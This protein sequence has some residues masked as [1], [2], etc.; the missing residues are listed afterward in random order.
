MSTDQR[1]SNAQTT[2]S[3][4]ATSKKRSREETPP[5]DEEMGETLPPSRTPGISPTENYGEKMPRVNPLTGTA[6]TAETQSGTWFEDQ[7]ARKLQ[8]DAEEKAGH[9]TD[10][11]GDPPKRKVQRRTVSSDDDASVA[12]NPAESPRATVADPIIDE[13]TH[14][15]GIGW[16]NVGETSDVA[17]MTRGY[18]RFIVNH[19]PLTDVEILAKS[20]GLK[21]YLVNSSEGYF[22][23]KEDLESGQL[24]A[25]TWEDTLVNLQYSPVRFSL[26]TP[27]FAVRTPKKTNNGMEFSGVAADVNMEL[28]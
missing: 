15:L 1:P 4:S 27:L 19:Y 10:F 13:Y 11:E 12:A 5:E 9:I 8:K 26:A 6:T 23:F 18:A 14:L 24:I 2:V 21:A 17:A 3:P 25:R 22:L 16:T 20:K 7:L 28:D